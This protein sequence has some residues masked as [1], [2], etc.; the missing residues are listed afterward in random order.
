MDTNKQFKDVEEQNPPK[1]EDF[2]SRVWRQIN[3]EKRGDGYLDASILNLQQE[4]DAQMEKLRQEIVKLRDDEVRQYLINTAA[5][6]LL[7]DFK[8]QMALYQVEEARKLYDRRD[9]KNKRSRLRQYLHT[10]VAL[11]KGV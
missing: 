2:F 7:T 10:C 8:V 9:A 1:A 4:V 5:Q 3:N 6:M 11:L